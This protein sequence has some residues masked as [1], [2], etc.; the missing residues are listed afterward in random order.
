MLSMNGFLFLGLGALT[1]TLFLALL[2][3]R[4]RRRDRAAATVLGAC[5]TPSLRGLV[6]LRVHAPLLS[7]HTTV[8]LDMSA[9]SPDEVWSTM[10][11]LAS[12]LPPDIALTIEAPLDRTRPVSLT[13][14]RPL[15]IPPDSLWSTRAVR[16]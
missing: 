14:R 8:V 9:C 6:A 16:R 15:G 13:L 4:D 5:A 12:V 7:R 11:R 1:L 3:A 10:R 2:N